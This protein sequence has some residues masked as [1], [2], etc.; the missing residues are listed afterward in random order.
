MSK[1]PSLI[2]QA[3]RRLELGW[4]QDALNQLAQA[5][6]DDGQAA[7]EKGRLHLWLGDNQA[8]EAALTRAAESLPDNPQAQFWLGLAYRGQEKWQKAITAL[9]TANDLVPDDPAALSAL[10]FARYQSG[11]KEAG[12]ELVRQSLRLYPVRPGTLI[13]MATIYG[14]EG[15]LKA[16]LVCARRAFEVSQ[17]SQAARN[18]LDLLES[19]REQVPSLGY[20]LEPAPRTEQE[21]RELIAVTHSPLDL[22]D[23]IKKAYR[24]GSKQDFQRHLDR[25][26][27]WWNT[28]PRPELGGL[29]PQ[30]VT[31]RSDPRPSEVDLP[32]PP[33]WWGVDGEAAAGNPLRRD[34]VALLTYLRDEKVTGTSSQG[35]LPLKAVHAVNERFVEP[36][37]L[38]HEWKD[39]TVS[40]PRSS[41]EV[42]R[43]DFLQALVEVGKLASLKPGRLIRL[44]DEGRDFLESSPARQLVLLFHTWWWRINWLY[45]YHWRSFEEDVASL[46]PLLARQALS[47]LP[48][49]EWALIEKVVEHLMEVGELENYADTT[50]RD[51]MT[52]AL[53]K[54][55]I[56]V[57]ADFGMFEVKTRKRTIG[58]WSFDDAYR[59]RLTRLGEQLLDTLWRGR[60]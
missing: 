60:P 41:Q 21:W 57:P 18:M 15:N 31:K 49:G 6:D 12:R 48:A 30:E 22:F 1:H 11:D 34:M 38:I 27:H 36:L 37:E 51:V 14:A 59:F 50:N 19:L 42:W 2:K 7:L 32:E 43:V 40:K 20:R 5:A 9:N 52:N 39:G 53:E 45:A 8:A 4:P 25:L 29:T 26:Q 16:A 44:T 54:M 58:T 56:T 28:T 24:V 33:L 3:L 10:G 17:G 46:L 55:V 23:V 47:A 13:D 35:N